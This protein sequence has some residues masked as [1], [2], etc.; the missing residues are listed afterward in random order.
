MT[1][2]QGTWQ[3]I[4]ARLLQARESAAH[5]PADDWESFF[6]VLSWVVLRFT[7]HGLDSARLTHE[8]RTT[9]DDWYMDHGKVYGGENNEKSIKSRFISTNAQVLF[10]ICS[11]TL[12]TYVLS[13]MKP[14]RLEKARNGMNFLCR[15]LLEIRPPWLRGIAPDTIQAMGHS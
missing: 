14:R 12:S 13:V 15:P 7:R 6:H 8:L 1:S 5:T 10:L 11:R 9:Y 3:F 4:A 2:L